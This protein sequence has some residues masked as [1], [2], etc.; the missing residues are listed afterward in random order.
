MRQ[1]QWIPPFIYI[2][3][4]ALLAKVDCKQ[5]NSQPYFILSTVAPLPSNKMH[6]DIVKFVL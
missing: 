6:I 4:L 3:K 5:K 1:Q 2:T